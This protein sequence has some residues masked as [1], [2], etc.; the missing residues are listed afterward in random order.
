MKV[1]VLLALFCLH[2][3]A[4]DEFNPRTDV[5]AYNYDAGPFLIYDCKEKHWTCVMD[6]HYKAC[7]EKRAKESDMITEDYYS[8]APLGEFP[9]KKSCFQRM[10]FMTGHNHGARFCIK[11]D[12]K[13]KAFDY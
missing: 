8:C 9:T 5:V 6:Y 11:D 4:G 2:G 7:E 13:T 12:L 10:L 1:F 3:F